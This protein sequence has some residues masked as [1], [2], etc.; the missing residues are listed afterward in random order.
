MPQALAPALP[1][2][3][4]GLVS[5]ASLCPEPRCPQAPR[6]WDAVGEVARMCSLSSTLWVCKLL[7]E[8]LG[9][10][11]GTSRVP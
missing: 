10:E 5:R 1:L 4:A 9:L 3:G 7:L 6:S 2:R 8:E 11:G